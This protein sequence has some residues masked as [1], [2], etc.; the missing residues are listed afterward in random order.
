MMKQFKFFA[1]ALAAITMFS[2]SKEDVNGGKEDSTEGKGVRIT[3]AKTS[4]NSGSKAVDGSWENKTAEIKENKITV[5]SF[6]DA[7]LSAENT[8]NK[9]ETITLTAGNGGVLEGIA[10]VPTGTG[11]IYIVANVDNAK[12]PV[13]IGV[14]TLAEL[15]A[16]THNVSDYYGAISETDLE[17][18]NT[19][20]V[21][22]SNEDTKPNGIANG[23][24]NKANNDDWKANVT[25]LPAMSRIQ[26]ASVSGDNTQEAGKEE[27]D[28]TAYDFV[29]IYL[30]RYYEEF[31]LAGNGAGTPTELIYVGSG[32]T[33]VAPWAKNVY[34]P[35]MTG[36]ATVAKKIT[37]KPEDRVITPPAT[38]VTPGSVWAYLVSPVALPTVGDATTVNTNM[39]RVILQLDNIMVNGEVFPY[40]YVTVKNFKTMVNGQL[41]L[42][43]QLDRNMIYHIEEIIFNASNL[44]EHPNQEDVEVDVIVTVKPWGFTQTTPEL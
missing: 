11:Y 14:T 18:V 4:L 27:T 13:N 23:T 16:I 35:A 28:I 34:T 25:I 5:Y 6:N 10:K 41:V 3:I 20:F 17:L 29:G 9:R 12:L 22:M 24:I 44:T 33:T 36:K 15:Q 7:A 39:P 2:C 38:V 30:N 8:L 21:P 37:Y 43:R 42:L 26:V 19:K 1:V 31:T 40:E 32:L